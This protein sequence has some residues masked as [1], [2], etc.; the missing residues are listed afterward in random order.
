MYFYKIVEMRDAF[1]GRTSYGI[2]AKRMEEGIT[3]ESALMPGISCDREF[4]QQFAEHCKRNQLTPIHM[5][6]VV[7]DALS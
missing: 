5:L 7:M 4:V 3:K 2:L 6:D 1:L